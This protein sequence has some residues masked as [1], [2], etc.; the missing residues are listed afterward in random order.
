MAPTAD[1]DVL[2]VAEL[3]RRFTLPAP[4]GTAP[5][6]TGFDPLDVVLEGGFYPEELVLV[7]GRPGVGKTV[8]LLQWALA[9]ATQGRTVTLASYEHGEG[10][11]L[12]RLLVQVLAEEPGVDAARSHRL[13]QIVRE[14]VL[15]RRP[16][17]PGIDPALDAAVGSLA[18]R[19][20]SLR[21]HRIAPSDGGVAA[22]EPLLADLPPGSPLI[23][24]HLQK[25]RGGDGDASERALA[26]AEGLKD[27]AT[28]RRQ[29]V[30]AAAAVD[31]HGLGRRR[32]G[33]ADLRGAAGLA[34]EADV[35]IML[36][37]MHLATSERHL[38]YD[39]TRIDLARQ[40]VAFSVVKNRR[41]PAPVHVEHR[42]QFDSYRF[43][44]RGRFVTDH[45]EG[46]L[47][48]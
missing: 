11:L 32:L 29:V 42:K 46:G 28:R 1:G 16:L 39:T 27:L 5:L 6:S 12:G 33:L 13:R 14:V 17:E 31:D 4:A 35:A 30:I 43:D 15:G 48:S 19:A 20:R 10:E 40:H 38:A 26:A 45:L 2:S 23:V 25:I 3:L 34:H 7:G 36:N 9:F 41:G 24:D 47:D 44:P 8:A 37:E 22:L 21:L 18:T